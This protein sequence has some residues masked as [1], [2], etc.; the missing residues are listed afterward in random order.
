VRRNEEQA[1]RKRRGDEEG[2]RREKEFG[3]SEEKRRTSTEEGRG[4][5][6]EALGAGG[7]NMMLTGTI[8]GACTCVKRQVDCFRLFLNYTPDS[9]DSRFDFSF[10]LHLSLTAHVLPSC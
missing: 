5:D 9:S 3:D 1:L 7:R 2:R 8:W 10:S 6:D 4:R